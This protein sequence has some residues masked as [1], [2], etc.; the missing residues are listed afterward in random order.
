MSP[1]WSGY[2]IAI[3][4]LNIV[5]AVWL[6][7][8][9]G[10]RRAGDPSAESTSH[11]WDGDITEYNNP[12]PRWWINL[13]YLTIL[14]A[15]AY[16]AWYPGFGAFSGRGG[17]S[18]AGE[19]AADQ[20]AAEKLLASHFQKFSQQPID[21]I[22]RDPQ[23]IATGQRIFANT[24]ATCHGSDARGGK[25]FPNLA[26]DKWQWGGAPETILQTIQNGRQAAMPPFA[27]A[28]G[29]PSN[30]TAT[31]IYVQSL[32][33]MKVD[34]LMA[35]I[36][37]QSFSGI[38]AACHGA[39]G[40]GNPAIGSANLTDDYW[41]YGNGID[42]IRAAIEHGHNGQMPAHKAILGET[43]TRL[44]GAYVYSLSHPNR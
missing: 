42:D 38:C 33:G 37:K 34:P 5:G 39:D 17:W 3:V 19:L 18:S 16:L 7:W 27:M 24:C 22:A 21:V 29:D 31:A 36:G 32:S 30:V 14:F 13:F 2:V 23:A 20:A 28:L 41:L 12:M 9:T 40:K 25:G 44:V 26:D 35:S 1:G 15:I 8:W 6:L 4:V 11:Y 10:R 43:R